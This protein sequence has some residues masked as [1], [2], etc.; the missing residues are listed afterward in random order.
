[1]WHLGPWGA[2]AQGHAGVAA[3]AVG[4][5]EGPGQTLECDDTQ[6]LSAE[7]KRPGWASLPSGTTRTQHSLSS[8]RARCQPRRAAASSQGHLAAFV[9]AVLMARSILSRLECQTTRIIQPGKM[10]AFSHFLP[11]PLNP[12]ATKEATMP[13]INTDGTTLLLRQICG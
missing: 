11:F 4:R 10:Y 13:F 7:F 1:M 9:Q 3:Q 5:D 2:A 12:T 6:L 8:L